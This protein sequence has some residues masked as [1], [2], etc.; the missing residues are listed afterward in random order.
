M[1]KTISALV[2]FSFVCPATAAVTIT[3]GQV[4]TTYDVKISYDATAEGQPVRAFAIDVT[5]DNGARITA[6]SN[7]NPDY[8]IYDGRAVADPCDHPDTQP[9]L[10][11]SGITTEMASLYAPADPCH[12]TAP[13]KSGDLL[14][15]T[16]DKDCNVTLALNK[17][18]RGVVMEDGTIPSVTLTGCTVTAGECY[19]GMPDYDQ[20]VAAG[21]PECWCY[22]RQCHGDADGLQEGGGKVPL[23]WVGVNDLAILG[24]SW[25][26]N[27][28][29]VGY[30]GCADFDHLPEGGDGQVRVWTNDLSIL[31]TYWKDASDGG[32]TPLP[33]CLPG[34]RTP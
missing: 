3:A 26:K 20:W 32:P 6:V 8:Y 15:F 31:G 11:S 5:V 1:N 2:L 16:V 28:G 17:I 22:P 24:T 10:G 19:T 9:G 33:D 12:T 25:K 23:V 7:T 34:N 27:P 21:K 14:T 13:P 18:R 29:D 30:N 4:G